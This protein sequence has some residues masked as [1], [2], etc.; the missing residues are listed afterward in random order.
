MGTNAAPLSPAAFCRSGFLQQFRPIARRDLLC[1]VHEGLLLVGAEF[2]RR[3][4]R[5]IFDLDLTLADVRIAVI[6]SQAYQIGR[7]HV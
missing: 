2:R 7:A 6:Y 3:R 4:L 5:E 1:L